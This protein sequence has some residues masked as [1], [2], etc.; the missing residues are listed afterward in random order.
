MRNLSKPEINPFI[1][2]EILEEAQKLEGSGKEI[3]HLEIGEPTQEVDEKIVKNGLKALKEKKY[4]YSSSLGIP[5][6]RKLISEDYKTNF[7][8]NI[9]PERIIL[10]SGSSAAILLAILSSTK[11]NEEIIIIDPHYPC[12]PLI[13]KILG[14]SIKIFRTIET[15]N[16]QIDVNM[17]KKIISNKTKSLIINSPANPTGVSQSDII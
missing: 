2:M 15:E 12:Y 6:L 14:R 16:Y 10:T 9:E 13:I 4:K 8:L 17:L 11:I 7:N 5:E 1:V 3:I